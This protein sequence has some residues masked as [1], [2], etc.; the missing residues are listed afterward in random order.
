MRRSTPAAGVIA[1]ALV[2]RVPACRAQFRSLLTSGAPRD[3]L[4]GAKHKV[5]GG[6]LQALCAPAAACLGV[7]CHLT[8]QSRIVDQ[9]VPSCCRAVATGA[10]ASRHCVH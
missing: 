10:A 5:F 2:E 6:A 4:P 7:K 8:T 9:C 3:P 1:A